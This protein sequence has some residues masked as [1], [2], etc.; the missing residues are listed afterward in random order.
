VTVAA[1]PIGPDD[2]ALVEQVIVGEFGSPA[3]AS[4][5]GTG[6][7]GNRP[8]SSPSGTASAWGWRSTDSPA[9]SANWWRPAGSGSARRCCPP[10]SSK[11]RLA[12]CR[13]VWLVTTNDNTG[14]LRFYQRNGFDLAELR[15]FAVD[16]ARR[17][18]PQIP[19]LGDDAIPIRHELVL[20]PRL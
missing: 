11:A 9:R 13:Q 7:C 4:A 3:I 20:E 14:V 8:G 12:G 6:T 17:V 5:D 16:E 2:A 18:K 1:R 15:R 10:S 19:A